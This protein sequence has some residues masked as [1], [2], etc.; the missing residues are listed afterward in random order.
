MSEQSYL[1]V[2]DKNQ[3]SIEDTN[4]DLNQKVKNII[5]QAMEQKQLSMFSSM[6][7]EPSE[8]IQTTNGFLESQSPFNKEIKV[9]IIES[10]N[11]KEETFLKISGKIYK[12]DI[13]LIQNLLND[14]EILLNRK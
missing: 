11:T 3:M 6:F 14:F 9:K 5:E 2:I 13:P 7:Y 4:N 8:V 10:L 12:D 1:E